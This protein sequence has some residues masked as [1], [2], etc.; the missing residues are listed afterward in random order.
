MVRKESGWGATFLWTKNNLKSIKERVVVL[1]KKKKFLD[2]R[3]LI[4]SNSSIKLAFID[5]MFR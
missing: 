3:Y 1:E 5:L 2:V 4:P